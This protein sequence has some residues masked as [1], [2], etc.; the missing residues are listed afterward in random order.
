MSSLLPCPT[1]ANIRD[2]NERRQTPAVSKVF[3]FPCTSIKHLVLTWLNQHCSATAL[4]RDSRQTL[5]SIIK[6]MQTLIRHIPATRGVQ[7]SFKNDS[8]QASELQES[9]MSPVP[10]SSNY[11]RRGPS[12]SL[13]STARYIQQTQHLVLRISAE[14]F[15]STSFTSLP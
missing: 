12:S 15:S 1:G 8:M 2:S 9:K 11:R 10:F 5:Q 3:S 14:R 7:I 4:Q 13:S 6:H